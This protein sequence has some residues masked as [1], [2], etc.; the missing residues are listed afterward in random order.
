MSFDED[1]REGGKGVLATA[2][3]D[4]TVNTAVYATPHRTGDHTVAWAMT[5]GRT[6][7]NLL[8]NPN[9]SYLYVAPGDGSQGRAD[10]VALVVEP[11]GVSRARVRE[12]DTYSAYALDKLLPKMQ[13][14]VRPT[15]IRK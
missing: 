7:R 10:Y 6:Y 3:V 11:V 4:G 9:A 5:E 2:G 14:V 1:W 13:K 8:A 12:L 15:I